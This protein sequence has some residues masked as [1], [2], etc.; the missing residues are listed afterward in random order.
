MRMRFLPLLAVVAAL[1]VGAVAASPAHA[2]ALCGGSGTILTSPSTPTLGGSVAGP[3]Q[4]QI[5]GAV[6]CQARLL[7][8]SGA[9]FAEPQNVTLTGAGTSDSLGLCSGTLLVTNL[10]LNVTVTYREVVSGQTVV[11]HESWSAP[12]TLFP[13][14]TPFLISGD[15]SGAGIL[16]HH[17]LL[18]CGNGGSNPSLSFDWVEQGP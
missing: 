10:N 15:R 5:N 11:D 13:L 9:F 6:A 1:I 16:L 7:T 8:S 2:I 17:L 3:F 4:W 12:V 14:V 18:T